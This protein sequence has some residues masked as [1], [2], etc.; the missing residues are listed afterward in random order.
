MVLLHLKTDNLDNLILAK[1]DSIYDKAYIQFSNLNNFIYYAGLSN[2]SIKIYN[3][4]NSRDNS[5]IYSSNILNVDCIDTQIIKN[6]NY[7]FFPNYYTP[8]DDYS[9]TEPTT[10]SLFDFSRCFDLDNSSYWMSANVY[11]PITGIARTDLPVYKFQESYGHW[12]KIKFPFS[13]IPIGFSVNSISNIEDPVFFDIY[14][15]ND[16]IN[17][18]KILVVNSIISNAEFYFRNNTNFYLYIT[19]VITKIN[20]NL[21]LQSFQSFKIY[22]LKIFS[23]PILNL[24]T[25]MKIC[26]NNIYNINSINTKQ[27]LLND[28]PITS[29]GDLNSFLI[30]QAF[31][32]F[33]AKYSLFWNNN[34][35][36]AYLDSNIVNK[37]AINSN[38]ANAYLDVNGDISYKHR[39]I[40]NKIIVNNSIFNYSSSYIY[41]GKITFLNNT[42]NYF[43]LSIYL[44]ELDKYY[45][46]T[47]NIYG[48]SS[49]ANNQ[50]NVYWKTSFDN[51]FTIQRIIDV[52]YIYDTILSTK[53]SI[54]FYIKY[55]DLLDISI[56]QPISSTREYINNLI[57]IDGLNT[58]TNN[59]IEFIYPIINEV[60]GNTNFFKAILINSTILNKFGSYY[61]NL[62]ISDLTILNSSF[63][64][65]NLLMINSNKNLSD[66]GIS[67]N[68]LKNLKNL[69]PNNILI[70]DN[71][72]NIN[73]INISSDLLSNI[74]FISKTN[75]NIL[76]SN[77]NLFEGFTI[78]K[79]N[80]SNLNNI[81]LIPNSIPFINNNNQLITSSTVKT[82]NISNVLQLFNFNTNDLFAFCNSNL[83]INELS[84]TSNLY[85]GNNI[86]TSNY[87]YNRFTVNNRE[88]ADDIFK[89]IIRIPGFNDNYA[90]PT[91]NTSGAIIKYFVKLDSGFDINLEVDRNDDNT[92]INYKI[93][94]IFN[95]SKD[96]FWLT[97]ANFRSYINTSYGGVKSL[98]NDSMGI[99]NCGAY[100]IIDLAQS[101]V[102]T[103]YVIYVNY[104]NIINSIRDFKLFGYSNNSWVLLDNI[105]NYLF[106]N[107]LSPNVFRINKNKFDVYSKYALCIVNTHNTDALIPTA[108]AINSIEFYGYPINNNYYSS[109]NCLTYN[110]E[111]NITLLSFSNVGINNINPYCY[112]SIGN[113]LNGNSRE[114]LINL[115]HPTSTSSLNIEKPIINITRPSSNITGTG[116]K[117]SHYLNSWYG[118]NTNYTIKLSHNN[119]DN[120]KV[121]LSMNSDGKV[122]IGNY[123]DS[124]LTSNGLSIFNSGL[125]FHNS[126]KYINFTTSNISSNY[127]VI[128]PS[129]PGIY[130]TTFFVNNLSNNI[131]SL[132]FDDPVEKM[133]RKP[134][135][136]FGDQTKVARKENGVVIQIAGNCL[137]G[138]DNIETTQL[139]S[140]Y[141]QNTLCVAGTIYSTIDISTDSDISYKYNIKTIEDPLDKINKINGYTF[142]RYDTNDNNRYSG[143][144]AQEVL[145]VMPEVI[146]KKHDGKYRIIYNNLAGL[147][148]EGIK[149]LDNKLFWLEFK[150]NL[151]IILFGS[152]LIYLFNK[153]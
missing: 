117:V 142:N 93:Y 22:E 38:I 83:K 94:N 2:N 89:L 48:Y 35:F 65:N 130:D 76:I 125:T 79:N 58:S 7:S 137:I 140:V 27:L 109:S 128:F 104:N 21:N 23:R 54:K 51:S 36:T 134:H 124:N 73:T 69:I 103:M 59:E 92:N 146:I 30:T 42:K 100:L 97:Q 115:N 8:I 151:S 71:Y 139:N 14:V 143:L 26:E 75:N 110:Y 82:D 84:I 1:F 88:I 113:D 112:L 12:I 120:E 47:I 111:N 70:S 99:T 24:D 145:K 64:C 56:N 144:I 78:N 15:S 28:I 19:I 123:P 3:P 17:W 34:N 32:A 131:I 86:I 29:I 61:S 126:N 141:L 107:N 20:I 96:F 108:V 132:T 147:F 11:S 50:F 53:T 49:I 118:S 135:I 90:T 152:S 91:H 5:L 150:L 39:S 87:K 85:I 116:V 16:D 72:G 148:V 43:N 74:N 98:Y 25:K 136:K 105:T 41:I 18:T 60:L 81:H 129:N 106:I 119:I 52:I 33:K 67:S 95:K 9:F 149:K 46:Q 57:Y 10:I 4:N 13:I 62:A 63:T 114:T 101:F 40:N 66:S 6:Y 55:N 122:A 127:S 153:F 31:D 45:F 37:L 68:V 102:L 138:K 133:V 44:Y 77:N 80:L 121:I